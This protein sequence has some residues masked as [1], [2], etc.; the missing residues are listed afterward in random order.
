MVR[1]CCDHRP[2]L[3]PV[4][5]VYARARVRACAC[6]RALQACANSTGLKQERWHFWVTTAEIRLQTVL[7]VPVLYGECAQPGQVDSGVPMLSNKPLTTPPLPPPPLYSSCS[8]FTQVLQGFGLSCVHKDTVVVFKAENHV[9]FVSLTPPCTS[10]LH[11]KKK[12]CP[13]LSQTPSVTFFSPFYCNLH[14]VEKLPLHVPGKATFSVE[15]KVNA[16]VVLF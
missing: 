12:T 8:K 9:R 7:S 11:R 2:W 13:L 3:N 6:N 16:S 1:V 4:C 5:C 15:W 14:P 10:L